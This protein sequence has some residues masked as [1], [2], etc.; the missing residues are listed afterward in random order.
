[1]TRT[2]GSVVDRAQVRRYVRK[3]PPHRG[4]GISWKE[5]AAFDALTPVQIALLL[6]GVPP[7]RAGALGQFCSALTAR[8][9]TGA[10]NFRL[11]CSALVYSGSRY[12]GLAHKWPPRTR[13]TPPR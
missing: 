1:M 13:V 4:G 2:M 11:G 10:T 12:A 5:L 9:A 8:A 7:A 3:F 6:H